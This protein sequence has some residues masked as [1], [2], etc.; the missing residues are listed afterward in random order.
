MSFGRFLALN[1][2]FENLKW[3]AAARSSKIRRRPKMCTIKCTRNF[4]E[5]LGAAIGRAK[6][7]ANCGGFSPKSFGLSGPEKSVSHQIEQSACLRE[8]GDVVTGR[9]AASSESPGKRRRLGRSR[10]PGL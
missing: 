1:I 4:G 7:R 6:Q 8:A 3:C 2:F 10:T 5:A 9:L